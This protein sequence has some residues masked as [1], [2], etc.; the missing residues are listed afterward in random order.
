MNR[1]IRALMIGIAAVVTVALVAFIIITPNESLI[2]S[3]QNGIAVLIPITFWPDC[4]AFFHRVLCP[5]CL[6]ILPSPF[7][8]NASA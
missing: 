4:L 3:A 8:P 1:T 5:F 2:S 6:R 7:K